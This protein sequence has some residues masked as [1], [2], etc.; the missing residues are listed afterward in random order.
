[1]YYTEQVRRIKDK[2]KTIKS[3]DRRL[4]IFGADYHKYYLGRPAYAHEV[5]EFEAKYKITLPPCYKSFI[6]EV[7][8]GGIEYPNSIVGNSA[9]GPN[10]GIYKLETLVNVLIQNT[11]YLQNDFFFNPSMTEATWENIYENLGQD[12]TDEDYD[13]H[14]EKVFSGILV[15]GFCGCSGYQGLV[16]NGK[17]KGRVIYLYDEVEYRPH[18]ADE[19]NFLDWYENWLDDAINK[20][21]VAQ[22]KTVKPWWRVW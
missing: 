20:S 22:P 1:M 3:L 2:L 4:E 12:I 10:Y 17:E 16:L 19:S 11:D 21:K 15:I 9:A 18:L 6:T 8:N 13:R 14:L 5:A 7:G